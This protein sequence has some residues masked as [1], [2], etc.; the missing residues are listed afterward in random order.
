MLADYPLGARIPVTD[1]ERARVFYIENL[2]LS[3]VAERR[4]DAISFAPGKGTKFALYTIAGHVTRPV[5]SWE[6]DE[7]EAEVAA[8]QARG[9]VFEE[10]DQPGHRTVNG[11]YTS[12]SGSAQSAYFRDS[13]GNLLGVVHHGPRGHR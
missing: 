13:E 12:P 2:G 8:L 7:V 9:V 5:A 3:P 10:Y 6:V 1:Y 4:G 11:I